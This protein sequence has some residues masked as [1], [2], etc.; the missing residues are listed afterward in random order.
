[1]ATSPS[2]YDSSDRRDHLPNRLLSL[3]TGDFDSVSRTIELPPDAHESKQ[4]AQLKRFVHSSGGRWGR[5]VVIPLAGASSESWGRAFAKNLIAHGAGMISVLQ[6]TERKHA[7]DINAIDLIDTAT[8]I[9]LAVHDQ[10]T[11]GG[12]LENSA[13]LQRIRQRNDTGIVVAMTSAATPLFA[14]PL[15]APIQLFGGDTSVGCY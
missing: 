15:G 5:V 10:S 9:L 12:V 8:G 13:L 3:T 11:I 4:C 7:D 2:N 14:I 6:L 1:M